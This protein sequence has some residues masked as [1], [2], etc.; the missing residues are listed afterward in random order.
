[1]S[2]VCQAV[3]A[4]LYH[5]H[6][7]SAHVHV[8]EPGQQDTLSP[9]TAMGPPYSGRRPQCCFKPIARSQLFK[10]PGVKWSL[11]LSLTAVLCTSNG[12]LN[13]SAADVAPVLA[14]DTLLLVGSYL[15]GAQYTVAR[16]VGGMG[17]GGWGASR[18]AGGQ[19]QLPQP[20]RCC[21]RP[22]NL[23][24][25]SYP[26]VSAVHTDSLFPP[27]M[28]AFLS[29][30]ESEANTCTGVSW[31]LCAPAPPHP[32]PIGPTCTSLTALTH[33]LRR[34]H[35]HPPDCPHT[36]PRPRIW[37]LISQ[38]CQRSSVVRLCAWHCLCAGARPQV[39]SVTAVRCRSLCASMSVS[40][41]CNCCRSLCSSSC[42][43]SPSAHVHVPPA[44]H[45]APGG[46][47]ENIAIQSS[48]RSLIRTAHSSTRCS[49]RRTPPSLVS[50]R[51]RRGSHCPYDTSSRESALYPPQS[52]PT[53]VGQ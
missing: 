27:E 32:L 20:G 12:D 44:R 28:H 9:R 18:V 42:P 10:T 50:T 52:R 43:R 24:V 5:G 17:V 23:L 11:L 34:G 48:L 8:A 6:M 2:S 4:K 41:L 21:P 38:W 14:G 29:L 31:P 33:C 36:L 19:V 46:G 51:G 39:P 13:K 7:D 1:M 3:C 30:T 53:W 47:I 22:P 40:C 35:V 49:Q 16:H 26:Q 15:Q 45:A 25:S 37:A